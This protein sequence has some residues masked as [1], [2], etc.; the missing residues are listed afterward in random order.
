MFTTVVTGLRSLRSAFVTG[1]LLLGSLFVLV[2]GDS[3]ARPQLIGSARTILDLHPQMPLALAAAAC[4]LVGSLY[5]TSLEGLVDWLHRK[6]A[7]TDCAAVRGRAPRRLLRLVV[8]YSDSSRGRLLIEAERFFREHSPRLPEASGKSYQEEMIQFTTTVLRDLLWM[9]GK[10]TG[11]PLSEAYDEYRA[12]GEFRFGLG[13]LLPLAA[14]AACY[15][16]RID[17]PWFGIWFACSVVLSAQ[18]CNHG[19]Y[20]Y[21]RAH[22]FLAHHIADGALL[23]P[24]METLRRNPPDASPDHHETKGTHDTRTS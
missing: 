19:L 5:T 14:F 16:A 8:P 6:L 1:A 23:A 4:F 11:S 13:L 2:R 17:S 3:T 20:Y 9:E 7:L 22:S 10:L 18:V 21:R 15:A 24:C 12:E